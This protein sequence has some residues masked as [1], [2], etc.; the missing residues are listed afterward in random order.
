MKIRLYLL[1]TLL[2]ISFVAFS[3]ET[4]KPASAIMDEAYKQASAEK[5]NVL[6]V[7]HASWCGWCK[8]FEA[9]IND[10]SCKDFFD[11]SFVIARLDVLEQP[12]K[13]N[14]ENEGATEFFHKYAGENSGIPFFLIFDK[15]GKLLAD[16]KMK[17]AGAAPEKALQNMG[18]PAS[19]EEVA[20]FIEILKKTSKINKKESAAITERFKKNKN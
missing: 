17:V 7:F 20:A 18:C 1:S 14:L 15:K 8:K 9:S 11:K 16:S 13:K 10:P 3:Q 5:K 6:V 4:P 2:L 19:E 12:A